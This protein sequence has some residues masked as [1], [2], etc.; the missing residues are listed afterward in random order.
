MDINLA[1]TA[2]GA[3]SQETRLKVFKLLIEYGPEGIAAG[4]L[5]EALSIPHNTLSFHLS[6]LAHAGLVSSN[7]K[8]RSVIYAAN[9]NAVES[10][11][12]YLK[13]NCCHRVRGSKKFTICSE[14]NTKKRKSR[15]L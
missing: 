6:H 9:V 7:R 4:K 11:I 15:E 1:T 13:D 2:F 8:G 12:E 3:L 14:P 5:S 10:L